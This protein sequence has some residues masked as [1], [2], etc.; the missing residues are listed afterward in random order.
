MEDRLD[1]GIEDVWAALTEPSRLSQ[2]YGEVEG[3]LRVG[4]EY[5][6]H[7]FATGSDINGRVEACEPSRRGPAGRF[8]S[9]ILAPTF[10]AVGAAMRLPDGP[11]CSLPMRR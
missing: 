2:W 3:D 10:P 5:R 4:G 11:S 1:A 6:A 9:K 7:V 8:T